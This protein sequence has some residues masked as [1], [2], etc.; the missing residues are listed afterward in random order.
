MSGSGQNLA[1]FRKESGTERGD[2]VSPVQETVD[3]A[4]RGLFFGSGRLPNSD[5]LLN[6]GKKLRNEP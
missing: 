3:R 2:D 5:E 4:F 1:P 6:A